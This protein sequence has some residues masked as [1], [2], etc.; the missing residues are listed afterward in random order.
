MERHHWLIQYL[1]PG[2]GRTR[3]E[4][5]RELVRYLYD[6]DVVDALCRTALQTRDPRVREATL[7]TL[8]FHA[9]G[10]ASR[11]AAAATASRSPAARRRAFLNLRELGCAAAAETVMRGLE[12]P[13][14]PV[15]RAAALNAGLYDDP[16][17]QEAFLTFLRHNEDAFL[18]EGL[19]Q[20]WEAV[21]GRTAATATPST[22]P[23]ER[24]LHR[25]AGGGMTPSPTR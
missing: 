24:T 4:A 12:D 9:S 5:A 20:A 8:A 3:V 19:R 21:R 2:N 15:R 16:R 6:E 25:S 1:Q 17:L 22:T 7:A 13:S 18:R 14:G 10:A 11:F 23:E